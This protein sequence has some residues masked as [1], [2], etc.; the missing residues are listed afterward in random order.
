MGEQKK[1]NIAFWSDWY[2]QKYLL[3]IN[4]IL[5]ILNDNKEQEQKCL[6][7]KKKNFISVSQ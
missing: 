6:F 5:K 3:F 1:I 4:I 7:L 2:L